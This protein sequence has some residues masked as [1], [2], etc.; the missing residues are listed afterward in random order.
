MSRARELAEI[1]VGGQEGFYKQAKLITKPVMSIMYETIVQ[2]ATPPDATDEEKAIVQPSLDELLEVFLKETEWLQVGQ[3]E[4]YCNMFAEAYE[5]V[6]TEEQIEFLIDL[7]TNNPWVTSQEKELSQCLAP[8]MA[9]WGQKLGQQVV[10]NITETGEIQKIMQRMM[11]R[12]D[13]E[14]EGEEWKNATDGG[15]G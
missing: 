12:I 15:A 10:A 1:V 3:Y 9:E 4:E 8:R 6:Y 14:G 5:E 7:Y 13:D 2:S 11:D